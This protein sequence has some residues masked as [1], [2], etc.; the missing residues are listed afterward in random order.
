MVPD[1]KSYLEIWKR[2]RTTLTSVGAVGGT[3]SGAA[4]TGMAGV[5]A[6]AASG[7]RNRISSSSSSRVKTGRDVLQSLR[8]G[9][10]CFGTSMWVFAMGK[11]V[12]RFGEMVEVIVT[13][14]D[15]PL[16]SLDIAHQVGI[17]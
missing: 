17:L 1:A 9:T 7:A 16:V 10:D 6:A 3:S 5:A 2:A 13:P 14:G 11:E 12:I 15:L 4:T 8:G